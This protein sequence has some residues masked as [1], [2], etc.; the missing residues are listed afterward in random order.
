MI[1]ILVA[2]VIAGIVVWLV[3]ESPMNAFF[4]KAVYAVAVIFL[5]IYLVKVLPPLLRSL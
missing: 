5:L 4:K 1:E 3:G 2:I